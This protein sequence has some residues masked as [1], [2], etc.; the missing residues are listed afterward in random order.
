MIKENSLNSRERALRPG[1]SISISIL[2]D[3][4]ALTKPRLL[5]IVLMSTLIGYL[6]PAGS[7]INF[8]LFQ[9]IFGT[10]LTGAGAHV[11]NQW[12]ERSQDARM[13][14]TKQRPLPSGRL[15]PEEALIFGIILS[16]LG[17]SYLA[18]TIN[19]IT[20]VLG[21]LTLGSYIFIYTPLKRLTWMN[22]WFGA[23][24]GSLPPL[25]G[26]AAQTGQLD[27]KCVPI[28]LLLYFWQLPHFFAIA[29]MYRD[30]Y[31]LGGFRML[32]RDDQHGSRTAFHMLVNGVLL[33]IS[34]L[35]FYFVEQG[36]L[37]FLLVAIMSG[38]GFLA[39]IVGF[40]K[41]RSV[42]RARMVFLVSIV[43]LP[44]LCTVMVIDRIF[45]I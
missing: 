11:L 6:L 32:S 1:E 30:D 24:T 9:L 42:E 44:V 31:R 45:I 33:L 19:L 8:T 10:A 35:T 15:E 14:R 34:S 41:V 27:W 12:Q 18:L 25:M 16:I 3:Y 20:A 23:V 37:F 13:M 43:Y 38:I 2:G 40:M 21:A 4:F 22:T 39:S 26:W 28:F 7:I 36:G 17:V 5:F 29:W